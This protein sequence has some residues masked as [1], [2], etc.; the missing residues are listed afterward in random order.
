MDIHKLDAE[1]NLKIIE[2]LKEV[3]KDKEVKIIFDTP[4]GELLEGSSIQKENSLFRLVKRE[5][6]KEIRDL[7]P[8][9]LKFISKKLLN[10]TKE[11]NQPQAINYIIK[12]TKHLFFLRLFLGKKIRK[13]RKPFIIYR[14]NYNN[15]IIELEKQDYDRLNYYTKYVYKL[16]QL[17]KLNHI[18]G[19][20]QSFNV[21]F[22]DD[23]IALD[24]YKSMYDNLS[25]ILKPPNKK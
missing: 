7:N 5:V 1:L 10:T 9:Y 20:E 6:F 13:T 14:I 2:S 16:Q 4:K 19:I 23:K 18:L 3:L 12:K 15:V 8:K 24:L 25:D 22:D 11:L 17:Q 21:V